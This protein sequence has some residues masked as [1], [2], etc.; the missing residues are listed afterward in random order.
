MFALFLLAT[1]TASLLAA[2][3]SG[4]STTPSTRRGPARRVVSL[5]PNTT[6][7]LFAIG[8]GGRVVGVSRYCDWPRDAARLPKV[9]GYVD[10]SLEA[11]LAL[12]PDL[13]VGARGPSNRGVVDRL[14][15]SGIATYFPLDR[16]LEDVYALLL[17]LGDRVGRSGAART[18]VTQLRRDRAAVDRA[19]AGR[20]RPRTL[21]VYG[22]RPIV[23]AGP[24]GFA[25]ELLRAA[26]ADNVVRDG[27]AYPTISLER[28][29]ALAPEVIVEARF[30]AHEDSLTTPEWHRLPTIPAVR[31][32]RLV[33]LRDERLIRPGPRVIEGV[34]VLASRLHPGVP[35]P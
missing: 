31:D 32:G 21:L 19:L 22:Y 8:A 2:C 26:G 23:V 15:E 29:E 7:A 18:L 13:V 27:S 30:S 28:V 6:E 1:I 11:I 34:R 35:L 5:T 14:T 17:G 20:H 33:V 12:R 10:P 24:G 3:A 25:D 16:S 4:G 9:G